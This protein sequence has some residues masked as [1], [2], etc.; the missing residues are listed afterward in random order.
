[1]GETEL[2]GNNNIISKSKFNKI[3]S[4]IFK[5]ETWV[6]IVKAATTGDARVIINVELAV[7]TPKIDAGQT[8]LI[9]TS[10]NFNIPGKYY[11]RVCADKSS[12]N[13]TGVIVETNEDNNCGP[14]T[15][16][17]S[18]TSLPPPGELPQCS[19]NIDND[20]DQL[21]DDLDPGCHLDGDLTKAYI[22]SHNNESRAPSALSE[23]N[24]SI[25]NDGDNL[26]D[27]NDPACHL[28][29]DITKDYIA[30][31]DSELTPP[32]DPNTQIKENI[33]LAVQQ[34]PLVFTDQEKSELAELLRK[35]YLLAPNLKTEDDIS[36]VYDE[37]ERYKQFIGELT[38]L[39]NQCYQQTGNPKWVSAP[40]WKPQGE[41]LQGAGNLNPITG[42]Y[43]VGLH[44]FGNPWYKGKEKNPENRYFDNGLVD[45][46]YMSGYYSGTTRTGGDCDQLFTLPPTCYDFYHPRR[47]DPLGELAAQYPLEFSTENNPINVNHTTALVEGCKWNP[48][49]HF[50]EVELL[51]NIW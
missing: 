16:I 29:G 49:T 35:F 42:N 45:C 44:R 39:T 26:I 37:I 19:D 41:F 34:N 15:A 10:Y 36:I 23:C 31:H 27:I 38:T 9:T 20:R 3:L 22:P 1:M 5:K 14:W 30:E 25:D 40:V 7:V 24:D 21:I 47:F 33:C 18:T 46:K 12:I 43:E 2:G 28:G 51:L 50:R 17:N 13:S 6:S 11:V 32:V 48:G 4:K 8:R